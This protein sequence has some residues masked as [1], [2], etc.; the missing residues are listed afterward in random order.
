M[1]QNHEALAKEVASLAGTVARVELNQAHAAELNKL[2]F[3]SLDTSIGGVSATLD[4][5]MGR[6]NAIVSGEVK[7]PQAQQGEKLVADYLAWREAVDSDREDQ[8]V[9]NGQVRLVGKI[10]VLLISTNF[11]AIIAAIYALLNTP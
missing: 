2:R 1:E 7:L 8:E 6:I 9:L 10:A 11:L 4:R 5:F 3:D